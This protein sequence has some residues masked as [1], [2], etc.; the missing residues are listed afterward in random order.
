M[1]EKIRLHQRNKNRDHYDLVELTKSYPELKNHIIPN[2]LGED[3]INYSDP[4]AVKI[5]NQGLISHYYGIKYWEF[6]EENL[7]PPIP[8]RADYIHHVADLL[9]ENNY[10]K[11][12]TGNNILCLDVGIGASC[13]YPIIGAV[14]YDWNFIGSDIDPK[15]ITS[16]QNIVNSNAILKDKIKCKL[17][18]N[19]KAIFHGIIAKEDKIDVVISNP[20][21]HSS[22]EEAQKSNKRKLTNLSGKKIKTPLLNFSGISHELVYEGGEYQFIENLIK[23]SK[24][25]SKNC[26]WFSTLVSKQKNLKKIYKFLEVTSPVKVKTIPLGTGNKS[27]RIIAWT[28][29]SREKQKEW[30]EDRWKKSFTELTNEQ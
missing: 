23:E 15:S 11:I 14:E 18:K 10:G 2:K 29:L 9:G 19:A 12:P 4:K 26:F 6:P 22:I 25:L 27:S 3:S 5:L 16:S 28:Y 17:Q 30:K 7:C 1:S 13:I 21:F 8:G 24:Q 20:P